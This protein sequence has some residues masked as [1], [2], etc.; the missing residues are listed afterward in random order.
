MRDARSRRRSRIVLE[1]RSDGRSS[2]DAIARI[3]FPN[4]PSTL[5]SSSFFALRIQYA[6]QLIACRKRRC[7]TFNHDRNLQELKLVLRIAFR[8]LGVLRYQFACFVLQTA[9]VSQVQVYE[10][11]PCTSLITNSTDSNQ[12]SQTQIL[13][14][15]RSTGYS[16]SDVNC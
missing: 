14:T 8:E 5:S 12:L 6:T 4:I 9:K 15:T 2:R 1:S 16:L 7:D 10:R 3:V 11:V 13:S